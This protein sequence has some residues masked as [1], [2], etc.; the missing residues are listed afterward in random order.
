MLTS[1]GVD[2]GDILLVEKID[3]PDDMTT[4]D[5]AIKISDIAASI[6]Y[7]SMTGLAEGS[8]KPIS[9]DPSKATFAPKFSKEETFLDFS[10]S[11][12]ELH[13]RVR[14]LYPKPAASC[15]YGETLIKI[16]E[17]KAVDTYALPTGCDCTN[18]MSGVGNGAIIAK[19]KEGIF[20]KTANGILFIKTLKPEGKKEMSAASWACGQK[21]LSCF[22]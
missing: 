8:I 9:Q 14:A 4:L 19:N 13:D 3:I 10:K 21:I 12:K 18:L 11:A 17:T 2:E 16:L 20:V 5:L 7:K 15:Y 22:K 6:L 1:I